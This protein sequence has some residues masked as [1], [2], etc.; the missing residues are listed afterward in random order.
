MMGD[1][2]HCAK[3]FPANQC[4]KMMSLFNNLS[5]MESGIDIFEYTGTWK[6]LVQYYKFK[7]VS[8]PHSLGTYHRLNIDLW[9]LSQPQY[10]ALPSKMDASLLPPLLLP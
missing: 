1:L 7:R 6:N 4:V 3:S 8:F 5:Q 2:D 9:Q 10:M